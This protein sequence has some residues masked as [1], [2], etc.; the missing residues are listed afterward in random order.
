MTSPDQLLAS[1]NNG[2]KRDLQVRL[3]T[4][5]EALEDLRPAWEELLNEVPTAT[6]FSTWEWLVPWWRAFGQDQKLAVLAFYESP[7]RLVGLAPFSITADRVFSRFHLRLLRLMGDG[8]GDSD[9]LDLLARP[10]YESE[11]ILTLLRYL[12]SGE[13]DWNSC[14][15]N[16]LPANSVVGDCLVRYLKQQ[17]WPCVIYP[18]TCSAIPLPRTW[19]SYLNQISK[20][21]REKLGYYLRR[22]EKRY[23]ARFYRCTQ[24]SELPVCLEALFQLHQKR[25]QRL[26]HQ[27]SFLSAARRRF[28]Y[29]MAQAFL[30]RK[31]LEFWLLELDGKAAAAQFTFRYRDTVFALQEGFDPAFSNDSIG[32]AL[33]GYA[34][35]QLISEG[36]RC[37]DFLAGQ[38]PSKDRLGAQIATY[39]NIHFARPFSS[40]G[41]HL[42]LR[43]SAREGKEWLRARVPARAWRMLRSIYHRLGGRPPSNRP[44][45][46]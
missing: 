32:Y 35:R 43:H 27:G 25:W 45:P 18:Q 23:R 42:R 4:S 46:I 12:K 17:S 1:G 16:T 39:S 33:R 11:M 8:S 28:Y 13:I 34:I 44:K 22:I 9:N 41:V 20:K 31:W 40:G 24:E 21:E 36:V 37:Y 38:D 14:Q 15:L 3:Y 7:L 30:S 5:L 26:S 2:V 6:I 19:E 10:G 29:E